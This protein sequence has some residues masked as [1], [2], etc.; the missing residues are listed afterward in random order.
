MTLSKNVCIGVRKILA[1][2]YDPYR[3]FEWG[4]KYLDMLI[5]LTKTD[6]KL[7]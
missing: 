3:R 1:F 6:C 7:I 4:S 2:N 5:K